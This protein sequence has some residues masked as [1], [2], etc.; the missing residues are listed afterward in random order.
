MMGLLAPRYYVLL[1]L[2]YCFYFLYFSHADTLCAVNEG[3]RTRDTHAFPNVPRVRDAISNANNRRV[4][5]M[6]RVN[7]TNVLFDPVFSA[8]CRI[9]LLDFCYVAVCAYCG[10]RYDKLF[11]CF[12]QI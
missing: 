6:M 4:F 1:S 5:Y 8:I 2:F 10:D 7:Y 3:F 9:L 12:Y 11:S